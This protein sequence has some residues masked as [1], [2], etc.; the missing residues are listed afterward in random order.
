M[1]AGGEDD[2]MW[3][4]TQTA[5]RFSGKHVRSSRVG[6]TRILEYSLDAT[7]DMPSLRVQFLDR[8]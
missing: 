8:I 4:S 7:E 1:I 6:W 2:E 3:R 5:S